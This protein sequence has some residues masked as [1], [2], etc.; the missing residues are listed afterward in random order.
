MDKAMAKQRKVA[1]EKARE[2]LDEHKGA[3]KALVRKR[4]AVIQYLRKVLLESTESFWLHSALLSAEELN[5]GFTTNEILLKSFYAL[6]FSI[7][8]IKEKKRNLA[9]VAEVIAYAQL[10]EEWE[11][12]FKGQTMIK[13]VMAHNCSSLNPSRMNTPSLNVDDEDGTNMDLDFNNASPSIKTAASGGNSVDVGG[14]TEQEHV[15]AVER[16]EK[17]KSVLY[18]FQKTNTI[19]YE[20]LRTPHLTGQHLDNAQ[21]LQALTDA[22]DLVYMSFLDKECLNTHGLY[23]IISHLD[24]RFRNVFLAPYM[25]EITEY[26]LACVDTEFKQI[27]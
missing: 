4:S 5:A 12:F 11:Y 2:K 21:V 14:D 1:L 17:T 10:M 16:H 19:V 15:G 20:Y 25:N 7:F 24:S 13:F 27:I 9:G 22:L 8:A 26:C 3:I 6:A 18:K 23:E